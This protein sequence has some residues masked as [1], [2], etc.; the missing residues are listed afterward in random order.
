MSDFTTQTNIKLQSKS[1][2][3]VLLREKN[4]NL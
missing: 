2:I 4:V 1:L 3:S